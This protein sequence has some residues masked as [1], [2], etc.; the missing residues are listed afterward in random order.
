MIARTRNST[1]RMTV[2]PVVAFQ[3]VMVAAIVAQALS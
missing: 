2:Y 3:V 1:A